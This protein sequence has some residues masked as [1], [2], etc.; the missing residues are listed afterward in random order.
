MSTLNLKFED[1][2]KTLSKALA[3]TQSEIDAAVKRSYVFN[4]NADNNRLKNLLKKAV[5]GHDITISAVGGSITEGAWA[6][7]YSG[8]GNNA[9]EYN[10]RLDGEKC[11]AERT[12]DWFSN[13]FPGINV[14]F[15][16]AGIGATPSFLGAFRLDSMALKH[17][18]D[19]VIVEFAVNDP[20]AAGLMD[21]E[22]FDAYEAVVRRS[23]NTDAAVILVF[24]VN[25]SGIGWQEY[26]SKVGAYYNVPMISYHNAIYPESG[27]ICEWQK[28]SPDNVHPNNVGHALIGLCIENFLENI[29][30][31]TDIGAV[32]KD[33]EIPQDWMYKNTFDKA[34]MI[35][36]ADNEAWQTSNFTFCPTVRD[37]C[38]K[39][40]GAWV[41][42]E[43][44]AL[45][46]CIPAGA[47]R[48][49]V[50]Y[51]NSNGS[52]ITKL[53]DDTL[54]C[55]TKTDGWDKASWHRV[56]T[57]APLEKKTELKIESN[58]DGKVIIIGLLISY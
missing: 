55:D 10:W 29:Y 39:W 48:V 8:G 4:Q 40:G 9:T 15:V 20:T 12:V 49:F 41:T 50:L 17:N 26:Y 34:E 16:N 56:H 33:S 37:V 13:K 18:P 28:L 7:S 58:G 2:V 53:G 14:N 1:R 43:K 27:L 38:S 23:L 6:V 45:S 25:E 3:V 54:S 21:T 19:L 32:Y 42:E 30:A 22:I 44:G 31:S 36:A 47:K 46:L 24:T 11:Y 57:G 5:S 51:F 52:F 35:Y